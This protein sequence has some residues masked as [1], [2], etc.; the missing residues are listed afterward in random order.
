MEY[1]VDGSP[2]AKRRRDH[3][4]DAEFN[5]P[6][7]TKTLLLIVTGPIFSSHWEVG[8]LKKHF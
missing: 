2:V 1:A 6:V 3:H 5:I 7:S 4:G 8:W